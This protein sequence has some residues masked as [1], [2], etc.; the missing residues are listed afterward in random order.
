MLDFKFASQWALSELFGTPEC[1]HGFLSYLPD[2]NS[3][4]DCMLDLSHLKFIHRRGM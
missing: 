2:S 1:Y 3:S 4:S